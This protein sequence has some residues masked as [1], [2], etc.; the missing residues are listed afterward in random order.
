M[1]HSVYYN[2]D[3]GLL[4]YVQILWNVQEGAW[5]ESDASCVQQYLTMYGIVERKANVK[6]ITHKIFPIAHDEASVVSWT[7]TLLACLATHD[8]TYVQLYSNREVWGNKLSDGIQVDEVIGS[9]LL[10]E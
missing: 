1:N 3:P 6:K 5:T 8:R 4:S 9:T 10:W 7:E 2:L